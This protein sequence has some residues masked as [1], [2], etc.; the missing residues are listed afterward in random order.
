[1]Q[2]LGDV[3]I[4]EDS[5]REVG[6]VY[7]AHCGAIRESLGLP[8]GSVGAAESGAAAATGAAGLPSLAPTEGGGGGA[9]AG[10]LLPA[11]GATASLPE[12]RG[13]DWRLHVTVASRCAHEALQPDFALRLGL[14]GLGPAGSASE[15]A[16][17]PHAV[18]FTSDYATL[19]RAV[20]A[21]GSAAAGRSTSHAKRVFKFL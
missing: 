7:E 8:R 10:A 17:G 2:S 15:C 12:F 19:K 1:L 14:A 16:A 9:G 21:L 6:G 3:M 11:S 20:A 18:D 5:K 13:L 4:S